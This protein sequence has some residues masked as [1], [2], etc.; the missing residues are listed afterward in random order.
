LSAFK[1]DWR[2]KSTII[3]LFIF[4]PIQKFIAKVRRRNVGIGIEKYG[5]ALIKFGRYPLY[6]FLVDEIR[7]LSCWCLK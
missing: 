5:Y 1:E 6:N 3:L 2:L 7:E 4:V